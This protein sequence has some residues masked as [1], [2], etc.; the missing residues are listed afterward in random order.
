MKALVTGPD[1]LLGSNLV[2]CLLERDCEVRALTHPSSRSTT[3]DGLNVEKITGDILD[4]D[5]M[6]DTAKGCDVVFHCAAST[7]TWPPR[8]PNITRINVDGTE[9]VMQA[10]INA[11][12]RRLIHVSSASAIGFG[13]RR[14]PGTEKTPYKYKRY[15][16]A[17][18]DSKLEG[19][20]RV[21]RRARR[22]DIDAVIVNPTFMFGPYDSGP[23]SGQMITRMSSMNIPFY[24]PG[25][26]NVVHVRDVAEAMCN[27]VESGRTGECYILGNRNLSLKQLF[28]LFERTIGIKAPRLP[29]PG[30]VL[31]GAGVAGSIV[32]EI[33]GRPV[34]ITLGI[35]KGACTGAYYNPAKA[36]REL[37]L[38]Q[39]PVET[40]VEDAYRWLKDNGYMDQA[41]TGTA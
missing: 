18:M 27:A 11:G 5:C 2:R 28:E 30:P 19:Q 26:K 17:Y 10:A 20:K 37:G 24:P 38:K 39:T 8:A 22:G 12:A 9:N 41:A 14:K 21:A 13:T 3:L 25:G 35:A 29:V 23:S 6:A 34:D 7:A 15:R 16:M 32:S 36:R 33:T 1:G 4:R 31:L 40:A